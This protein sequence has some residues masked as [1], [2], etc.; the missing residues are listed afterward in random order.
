MA[1]S[2]T[3]SALVEEEE[4]KKDRFLFRDWRICFV[5]AISAEIRKILVCDLL[6]D[7]GRIRQELG[8]PQEDNFRDFSFF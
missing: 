1:E 6:T 4:D 3:I 5:F 7:A 8:A 2:T